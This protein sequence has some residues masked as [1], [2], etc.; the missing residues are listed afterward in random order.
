MGQLKWYVEGRE[1]KK[2]N[3]EYVTVFEKLQSR[4]RGPSVHAHR[5]AGGYRNHCHPGCDAPA[6]AVQVKGEGLRNSLHEQWPPA[7]GGD[8]HVPHGQ[9]RSPASERL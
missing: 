1:W 9:R 4:G 8:Y 7:Y 6:R 3:A 2:G 5:V